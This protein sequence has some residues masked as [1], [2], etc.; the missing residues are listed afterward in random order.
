MSTLRYFLTAF[1]DE[2]YPAE[3]PTLAAWAKWLADPMLIAPG[4]GRD[5]PAED[6]EEFDGSVDAEV[7]RA[8]H[9]VGQDHPVC[10]VTW[11]WVVVDGDWESGSDSIAATLDCLDDGDEVTLAFYRQIDRRYRFSVVDG[12]PQLVDT[13]PDTAPTEA[14]FDSEPDQPSL[15]IGGA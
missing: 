15:F 5:A 3:A 2:T 12:V 7:Y 4:Y 10:P 9:I 14:D 6:G 11:V 8:D 13:D 1:T